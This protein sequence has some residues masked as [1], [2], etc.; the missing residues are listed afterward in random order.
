MEPTYSVITGKLRICVTGYI[1]L[2]RC[3]LGM[4]IAVIAELV[5]TVQYVTKDNVILSHSVQK[6]LK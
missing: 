2:V 1:I 5:I 4:V 6:E 3:M